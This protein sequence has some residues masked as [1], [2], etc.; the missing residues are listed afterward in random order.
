MIIIAALACADAPPTPYNDFP[1]PPTDFLTQ[2][3][4]SIPGGEEASVV[5]IIDGD[6][7]DVTMDGEIYRVRY[8]GV[9][10]PERN[11]SCYQEAT[12][13]NTNLVYQQVVTLVRDVSETDR[14]DRLLRYIYVGGTFVNAAL[15]EQGWA[16]AKDYPPDSAQADYL[17]SLEASAY[18]QSL[19]CW[20]FGAFER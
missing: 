13:A 12:A 10:T 7:I 6:T 20:G 3:E 4:P 11:E 14:Y 17:D 18:S 1:P 19:G 16:E 8:I 15:V 5:E 9:N 2:S